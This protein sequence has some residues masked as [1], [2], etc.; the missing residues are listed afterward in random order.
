[1]RQCLSAFHQVDFA[2]SDYEI[3]M[4]DDG[5]TDGTGDMVREMQLPCHLEYVYKDHAGLAA[6]RNAGIRKA[7]GPIILFIDDDTIAHPSLLREHW[8]MHQRRAD[9]IVMGWVNHVESLDAIGR[10]RFTAADISTHNFWTSNVSVPKRCLE[11]AGMFDED[12]TEYGWED[13][14]LGYRLRRLGIRR[15]FSPGAIVYHCKPRWT[16]SDL[17]SLIRRAGSSGRS[18]VVY[19]RKHPCLRARMSTGVFRARLALDRVLRPTS[20]FCERVA[21]RAKRPRLSGLRLFCARMLVSFHY[22]QAVRE[23]LATGGVRCRER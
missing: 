14:E 11:A 12:F 23:A 22:F 15:V 1:M 17:P 10:P 20:G 19:V 16:V 2:P 7:R 8:R 9:T 5:S 21:T 4:V 18:A 13:V 6:G 3:V